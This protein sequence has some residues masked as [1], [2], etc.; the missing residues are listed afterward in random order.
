[1]KKNKQNCILCLDS[2]VDVRSV[3]VSADAESSVAACPRGSAADW[4]VFTGRGVMASQR[5]HHTKCVVALARRGLLCCFLFF[6]S[7]TVVSTCAQ[8]LYQKTGLM[9]CSLPVLGGMKFCL[10]IFNFL[11]FFFLLSAVVRLAYVL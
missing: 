10:F 3:H 4:S 8:Y 2:E 7:S 11:F 9:S 5:G 1:M 6:N